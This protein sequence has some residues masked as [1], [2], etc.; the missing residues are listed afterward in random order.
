MGC[1]L[2]NARDERRVDRL[3]LKDLGEDALPAGADVE[4]AVVPVAARRVVGD[5]VRVR[6]RVT[7]RVSVRVRVRV[8]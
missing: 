5:L 2:F 8:R 6:V 3:L 7:V 1:S 4:G